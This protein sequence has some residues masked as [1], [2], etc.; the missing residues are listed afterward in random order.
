[1]SGVAAAE[2]VRLGFDLR[3][4]QQGD[5][6]FGD[7]LRLPPVD[8]FV[9]V[10]RRRRKAAVAVPDVGQLAPREVTVRAP[11]LDPLERGDPG[12]CRRDERFVFYSVEADGQPLH[13]VS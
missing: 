11:G 2:D 9:F 6:A 8:L 13:I 10:V 1:V 3:R 5:A 7:R 4:A 12:K